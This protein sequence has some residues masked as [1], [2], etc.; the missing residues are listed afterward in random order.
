MNEFETYRG[1]LFSIA[2]RMLGSASDAE[3]LVQDAFIR[4]ASADRDVVRDVRAFLVT[5]LTRLAI[6]RLKSAQVKRE[7]YVGQWLPEPVFTGRDADPFAAA[8]RDEKV[9]F[10]LLA[11]LERLSPQERAVLLL[12]D[13]LEYDHEEVAETIGISAAA[14]RQTLHRAR[15]RVAAEKQRFRPSREDQERLIA[16]FM[17][18]LQ[19]G[20]AVALRDVLASDVVA[21]GDGGGKV[22]GAGMH[23]IVGLDNVARL[24]LGVIRKYI[25][26]E[27]RIAIEE[28]NGAPAVVVYSGDTI[29]GIMNFD[30]SGGRIA[31]IE[32]VLN[33]DKLTF[34]QRQLTQ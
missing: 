21:C 18:A 24:W 22:P 19:N 14:S 12:H 33:P 32:S 28:V 11:A 34:A 9:R 20:D 15:E 5:V 2:Y 7:Q 17:A 1:L 8:A 26:P 13:V 3:D 31:A 6:D 30:F 4:F 29:F 27:L 16:T 23:P 10:A 25:R